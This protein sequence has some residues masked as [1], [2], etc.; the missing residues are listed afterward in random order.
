LRSAAQIREV[1]SGNL[2]YPRILQIVFGGVKCIAQLSYSSHPSYSSYTS[3]SSYAPLPPNRA[4][5]TPPSATCPFRTNPRSAP[6]R[7]VLSPCGHESCGNTRRKTGLILTPKI[8]CIMLHLLIFL[9]LGTAFGAVLAL[10]PGPVLH[11]ERFFSC[12]APFSV[13]FRLV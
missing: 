9:P 13:Q 11:L 1:S 6:L 12:F 7:Q 8:C 10:P 2:P 4:P 3:C 5:A